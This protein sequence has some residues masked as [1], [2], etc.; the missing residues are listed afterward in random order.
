MS[1]GSRRWPRWSRLIGAPDRAEVVRTAAAILRDNAADHPV[2]AV[3]DAPPE[4]D[5]LALNDLVEDQLPDAGRRHPGPGRR[6]GATGLGH[7][8][9]RHRRRPTTRR[10]AGGIR[11]WHAY[12]VAVSAGPARGRGAAVIVL[13]ESVHRPVG[14]VARGLRHAVRHARRRG[15]G[16]R[17]PARRRAPP[18][19]GPGRARRRQERVLHQPQPRA[20]HPADPHRRARCTRRWGRRR[21]PDQRERLELVERNTHRLA[22]MVDAMLDFGRIEAGGL[23]P[24]RAGGRRLGPDRGPGRDLPA[25]ARAGRAGVLPRL[26]HRHRGAPRPRHGRA[27]RAQPPGERDEVHA[28]GLGRAAG[29]RLVDD[30]VEISVTDT[31]VGIHPD[32]VERAFARFER[33]PA[34]RR[35]PLARGGRHRPGHGAAAHRA[36]GR[37]GHRDQRGGPRQHLHGPAAGRPSGD[38]RRVPARRVRPRR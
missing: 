32:D 4:G 33:L 8:A 5:R 30:V 38:R 1:G 35:R 7:R 36:D 24:R 34:A 26:R 11:A 18:P 23:A 25:G 16:R 20:A 3:L 15:A 19:A 29:V 27:D 12:P 10:V 21:T 28:R 6:P 31:G 9:P 37:R 13:G 22:R 17:Q 14:P 2:V